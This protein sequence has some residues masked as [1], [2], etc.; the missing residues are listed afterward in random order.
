MPDVA[1]KPDDW[2]KF[3]QGL[4]SDATPEV[5]SPFMPSVEGGINLVKG[6]GK[7]IGKGV[8][9]MIPESIEGKGIK[10]WSSSPG[11]GGAES[12]GEWGGDAGQYR[13]VLRRARAGDRG[14]GR[15][16]D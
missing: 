8:T 9:G 2:K 5:S 12:V 7:G 1:L 11:E 16:A 4:Q 3:S 10:D 14:Q 13:A 15:R 6:F